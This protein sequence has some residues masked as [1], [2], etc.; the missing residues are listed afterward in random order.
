MNHSEINYSFYSLGFK[1][2]DD[3]YVAIEKRKE[4]I[5][6]KYGD[7]AAKEY[8]LGVKAGLR[9]SNLMQ[10]DDIE[11][12]Q[13]ENA[14]TNYSVENTRN[15]SYFGTTGVGKQYRDIDSYGVIKYNE[16]SKQRK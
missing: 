7:E 3:I 8:F 12:A 1:D 10:V 13:I 16:P 15:N 14:T 9:Q 6:K 11:L 5:R 2:V 4:E